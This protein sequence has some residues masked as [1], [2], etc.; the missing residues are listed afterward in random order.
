MLKFLDQANNLLVKVTQA[1]I[2]NTFNDV[3]LQHKVIYVSFFSYVI[4][5]NPYKII[6]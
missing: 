5:L 3:I 2:I 6:L 4:S 1:M